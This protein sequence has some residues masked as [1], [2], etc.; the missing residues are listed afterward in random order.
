MF[1]SGASRPASDGPDAAGEGAGLRKRGPFCWDLKEF[2]LLEP[3]A[4][5]PLRLPGALQGPV[6][7][8]GTPRSRVGTPGA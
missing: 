7:G 5:H 2:F 1:L 4:L 3:Q 8:V 6:G